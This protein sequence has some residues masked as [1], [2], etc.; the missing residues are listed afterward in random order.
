MNTRT[1]SL[2]VPAPA[3]ISPEPAKRVVAPSNRRRRMVPRLSSLRCRLM[4][5]VLVAITPGLVMLYVAEISWMGFMV[6][7]AALAAAWY[8][9]ER[10]ILRHVRTLLEASQRLAAGDLTSRTGMGDEPGELGELARTFDKMADALEQ[11]AREH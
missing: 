9:G 3:L 4:L 7:L 6:G 10:F 2:S 5:T 11:R 8:G 1:A